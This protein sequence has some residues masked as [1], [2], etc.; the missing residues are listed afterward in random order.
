MTTTTT[1]AAR[2]RIT[3]ILDFGRCIV[4]LP[5]FVATAPCSLT[6][7]ARP[8]ALM[9]LVRLVQYMVDYA[10]SFPIWKPAHCCRHFCGTRPLFARF[11]SASAANPVAPRRA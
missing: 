5:R 7:P 1:K 2:S 10:A 9:R 8:L 3:T 11:R 4:S 6:T